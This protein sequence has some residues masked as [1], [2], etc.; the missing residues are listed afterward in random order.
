MIFQLVVAVCL[1]VFTLNLF[2]NLKYFKRPLVK[3]PLPGI[4]PLISVMIPARN[5]AL[6]IKM[7]LDSLVNQDYPNLEILVLDDNSSDNTAEIVSK[8]AETDNRIHLYRGE[9]LPPDWAGKPFACYQLARKARGDWLLFVDA[10]TTHSPDM[11]RG[12][13]NLAV[14]EKPGLL[15]GF[16]RQVGVSLPQQ[17]AIPVLYFAILGWLPLWWIHRSPKLYPSLAIGQFLLFSRESYWRMNGHCAVKDRILEDVWL[18]IEVTKAGRR[19]IAVDLSSV[20]SCNM[21]RTVREMSNGF[22]RWVYSVASF[23]PLALIALMSA[24]FIFYLGPFF[25]LW[26]GI[27]RGYPAEWLALVGLQVLVVYFMRVLLDSRFKNPLI[28]TAL[29]PFGFVFLYLACVRAIWQFVTGRG[30][31]WKKRTYNKESCV[32]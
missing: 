29:H 24:G 7:C 20:T 6:N 21:Y 18:G 17:V 26:R 31:Q 9:K 3:K 10:D 25:W 19:H 16:P 14:K 8:M 15:S 30:I 12:I 32:K 11:L 22:V 28:S 27:D 1:L 4:P 23:T 5:E 2:L 13:I